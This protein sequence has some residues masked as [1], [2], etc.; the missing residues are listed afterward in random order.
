MS[1]EVMN[2][3]GDMVSALQLMNQQIGIVLDEMANVRHEVS[4]IKDTMPLFGADD[5][6][7]NK[8]INA[9]I[10]SM[11]GGKRSNAYKDASIHNRAFA[12]INRELHRQFGV[13]N[14]ASILRKDM[15]IAKQIVEKYTFPKVL[16]DD[17]EAANAQN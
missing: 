1:N 15:A 11:L 3:G 7:L 4:E 6:E 10:V 14:R 12:D 8:L 16:A 17:V 9:K 5:K 2:L 13:A